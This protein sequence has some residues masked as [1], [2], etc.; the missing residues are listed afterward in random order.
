M[1]PLLKKFLQTK[2]RH[3]VPINLPI[4]TRIKIYRQNFKNEG[5]DVYEYA[6]EYIVDVGYDWLKAN[7]SDEE[8]AE[9]VAMKLRGQVI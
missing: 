9:F 2:K 7:L 8:F 1:T 5:P 3:I 4:L 6:D